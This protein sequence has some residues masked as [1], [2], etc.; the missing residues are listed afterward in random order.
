MRARK[1]G[2]SASRP[3]KTGRAADTALAYRW[4]NGRLE[5][6]AAPHRVRLDD[7]LHVERQK[8][9]LVANTRQ[10]VQGLPANHALLTGARGTGKSSLVKALLTEF[11]DRGLRLVEVAPH[12]LHQLYDIVRPLRGSK[13]RFVLYVDDFSVAANDPGLSALKAALDGDIEAPPDNVLIYATSNRR[14]LMPEMKKDNEEYHWVDGE[15]HPGESTEEKISLSERF[16]LWLSFPPFGQEQFLDMV[17]HH[18]ARLG[19]PSLTDET[20]KLAL[21]WALQR[22]SRSGRVAQQFARELAGRAGA[23]PAI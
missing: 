17:R 8:E 4:R 18:L 2:R 21:R 9:A 12:D 6:I 5:P 19:G 1:G 14:H 10:F 15:L 13:R 3:R 16:G 11:A 20:A 23:G 22:A 7:L